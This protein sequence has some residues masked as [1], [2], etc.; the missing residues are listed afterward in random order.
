MLPRL[1]LPRSLLLVA[2]YVQSMETEDAL[3]DPT[4]WAAVD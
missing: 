4:L 3:P 2:G 1:P